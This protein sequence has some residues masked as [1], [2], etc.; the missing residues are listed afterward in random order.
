MRVESLQPTNNITSRAKLSSDP[1]TLEI[2]KRMAC[3]APLTL[4]SALTC[5]EKNPKQDTIALKCEKHYDVKNQRPY[6]FYS[7]Q[8]V[9]SKAEVPLHSGKNFRNACL[10]AVETLCDYVTKQHKVLFTNTTKYY[11]R[12]QT[13]VA[14][15]KNRAKTPYELALKR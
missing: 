6:E 1:H 7:A 14:D 5:L 12:P 4:W 10:D 2:V 11:Q 13:G 15:L 9:F 3:I 8:N